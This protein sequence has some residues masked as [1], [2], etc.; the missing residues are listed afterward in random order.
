MPFNSPAVEIAR[1]EQRYDGFL[2]SEQPSVALLNEDDVNRHWRRS[3]IVNV[4]DP[5]RKPRLLW[6]LSTDEEY[7][8]PIRSTLRDWELHPTGIGRSSIGWI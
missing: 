1:T 2:W 8:N 6:D 4:D 3:F 7:A 5:Q